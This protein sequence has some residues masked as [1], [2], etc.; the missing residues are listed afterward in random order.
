[1]RWS[2]GGYPCGGGIGDARTAMERRVTRRRQLR[3]WITCGAGLAATL[4]LVPAA[5]AQATRTAAVELEYVLM[6]GAESCPAEATFREAVASQMPSGADPFVQG[7]PNRVRV[8]LGPAAGGFAGTMELFGADGRSLGVDTKQAPT[9]AAVARALALSAS[10]LLVAPPPAVSSPSTTTPPVA[11]APP[12]VSAVSPPQP[13]APPP[14]AVQVQLGAGALVTFGFAPSPSAGIG[15]FVGLR[16][17]RLSPVF[18]LS[19]EARG[20]FDSAG[21]VVDL[22]KAPAQPRAGFFLGTVAPC[23]HVRWFFGCGLFTAGTAR[24]TA[25]DAYEPAEQIALYIGAGAR[26]GVEWLFVEGRPSFGVR[27]ALDGLVTI[28]RPEIFAEG[29]SIWLAPQGA[30]AA[31]AYVVTLF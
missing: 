8:T 12:A 2:M 16:F 24:G 29:E 1:M 30:G 10:V 15:G 27:L 25:G 11:S 31:G 7:A 4:F 28:V 19:A 6:P 17:P 3:A 18:S 22:A 23:V 9:C 13:V 5:R 20:D 26:A 21:A 14:P